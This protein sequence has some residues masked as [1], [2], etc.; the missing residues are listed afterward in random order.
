MIVGSF[1]LY[2]AQDV[3]APPQNSDSGPIAD[4]VAQTTDGD[5][6]GTTTGDAGGGTGDGPEQIVVAACCPP[7]ERAKA[8]VLFD[9]LLTDKDINNEATLEA[10][11]ISAFRSVVVHATGCTWYAARYEFGEA[12][13]VEGPEHGLSV[14]TSANSCDPGKQLIARVD[15]ELG[16]KVEL[17]FKVNPVFDGPDGVAVTVVGRR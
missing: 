9:G 3:V 4:V 7:P 6:D 2:C 16:D 17:K 15:P 13:F 12:G 5:A 11:D 8:E 14:Q 10:I 1:F